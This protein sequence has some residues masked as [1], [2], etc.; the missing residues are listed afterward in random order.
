M[1]FAGHRAVVAVVGLTHSSQQ[2]KLIHLRVLPRLDFIL[3]HKPNRQLFL[4]VDLE[5]GVRH[6]VA[7]G[8]GMV[9]D[10]FNP[11]LLGLQMPQPKAVQ[12]AVVHVVVG[13]VVVP[14]FACMIRQIHDIL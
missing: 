3:D 5:F 4:L 12:E 13:S 14:Q 8:G 7:I 6:R 2:G 9:D 1:G 11:P 10:G